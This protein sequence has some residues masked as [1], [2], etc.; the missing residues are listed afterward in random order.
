MVRQFRGRRMIGGGRTSVRQALD[1]PTLVGTRWNP[2]DE[3]ANLGLALAHLCM[4]VPGSAGASSALGGRPTSS[5]AC[6]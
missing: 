6:V 5:V 1:T 3:I 4:L 2:A